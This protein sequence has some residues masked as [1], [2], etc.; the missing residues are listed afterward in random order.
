MFGC[1]KYMGK[2]CLGK[3]EFPRNYAIEAFSASREARVLAEFQRTPL[4]RLSNA[5][6]FFNAASAVR[7]SK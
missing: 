5:S 6:K 1:A 4:E 3:S 7:T 2:G